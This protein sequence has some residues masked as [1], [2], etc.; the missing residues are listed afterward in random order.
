M[1]DPSQDY[2]NVAALVTGWGITKNNLSGKGNKSE[3]LRKAAVTTMDCKKS[4]IPEDRFTKNMICAQGFGDDACNG[5]TGG[6]LAV[7]GKDGTYSQI[8][9]VSWGWF[10]GYP[11]L[12]GVYTSVIALLPWIQDPG[13]PS[14]P[15]S[16]APP[17]DTNPGECDPTVPE[18]PRFH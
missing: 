2:N 11:G 5:D 7:L 4:N 12:P 14:P 16:P 10:C 9:V 8:G 13:P 3:I 18:I 15:V 6:P 1:P 17:T